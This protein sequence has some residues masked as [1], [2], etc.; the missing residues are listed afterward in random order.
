[1]T[2][3]VALEP[4]VSALVP[5]EPEVMGE[6]LVMA[7]PQVMGEP[8]VIAGDGGAAG[9]SSRVCGEICSITGIVI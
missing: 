6:P 1:M 7:E 3:S 4:Q 9:D 8:L 5:L 2:A